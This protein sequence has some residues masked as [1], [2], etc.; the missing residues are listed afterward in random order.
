MPPESEQR[1]FSWDQEGNLGLAVDLE[2]DHDI[3]AEVM[4]ENDLTKIREQPLYL[5]PAILKKKFYVAMAMAILL[6]GVLLGRA[7]WMQGISYARFAVLSD[8][9]R[10]RTETM[11]APRGM[12]ADRKG[13]VLADNVSTFDVA[14]IPAD[15]PPSPEARNEI[16][17]QIARMSGVS[18]ADLT[19]EVSDNS[20]REQQMVL[21]RD[22]AYNQAIALKI[23]L[24][25]VPAVQILMGQKRRYAAAAEVMSI[26]HILGYVGKISQAEYAD[27][28]SEDY[29]ATDMMG[30]T[31][32]EASY[33]NVLRGTP[34]ER[35]IEVDAHGRPKRIVH[36]AAP[37]SGKR[38]TLS[39]D[40]DLQKITEAALRRGIERAKVKHGAAV[41]MDPRDGSILAVASWPAYDN[42]IFSGQVSSTLYAALAN[43][44]DMPFLARAWAGLYPSGSTIKP[45]YAAAALAE[46]IITPHTAVNST[47]GIK[48]G[49]N[50]FPDWK[51]GGHGLTDVRRAIAWSVNTFFYV[52]CGGYGDVRGMGVS[53]MVKWLLAFGFGEKTGLDIPGEAG[54]L[55]P[56]PEWTQAR[57][58][59]QWRLGDTYNLA[60]GQ[61]D[62]LVTPLQIAVL[63]GQIANGGRRLVP[64]FLLNASSTRQSVEQGIVTGT[65]IASPE[66]IRVVRAGMR[67][68]VAY[69]SG[70]VLAD[71]P[72]PVAGKTGTA[73]WRNDKPNHA[74]FTSFAPY[75]QP[76][77]VVTVLLEEGV[78]GSL[79]AIPVAREI[80]T[81]WQ[82]FDVGLPISTGNA[83]TSRS[84][85]ASN[86]VH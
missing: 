72:I 26:S 53:K 27:K 83:T 22:L 63:T 35:V 38:V 28:K 73:Q 54:G 65:Q 61:G 39:V 45:V 7:F 68:T 3:A 24:G 9:N 16:L 81:A 78:E 14:L 2:R 62:L 71:L 6:I 40:L 41:V 50:F 57:R 64:H 86:V 47:G 12:I 48:I 44:P 30:K 36:D 10:L 21:V 76:R 51:A 31:G 18:I 20:N 33:E 17:G 37:V 74:W 69:G 85:R 58:N 75:D 11:S 67:D 59:D 29:L 79:T 43:S 80:L 15:L 55:V 42:N 66:V 84:V 52:V 13:N 70:R 46:G 5:G 25:E 60:I 34:G 19:Q 49:A 4:Y 1:R 32:V 8:R 77:V 82:R 23:R 56:T